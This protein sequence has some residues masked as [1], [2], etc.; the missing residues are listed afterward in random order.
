MFLDSGKVR[1]L[2]GLV[3]QANKINI[4]K[5]TMLSASVVEVGVM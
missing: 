5:H 2:H 1:L 3:L 4:S